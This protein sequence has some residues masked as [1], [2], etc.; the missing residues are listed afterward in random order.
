[1]QQAA[2][3]EPVHRLSVSLSLEVLLACRRP[4][5]T[6]LPSVTWLTCPR[7]EGQLQS[8]GRRSWTAAMGMQHGRLP[9]EPASSRW[10]AGC[11]HEPCAFLGLLVKL[12]A[13]VLPGWLLKLRLLQ[14]GH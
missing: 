11:T 14:L 6:Q 13:L 2:A 10:A 1:M 4:C 8:A 9:A 7:P 12:V 3:F 5:C